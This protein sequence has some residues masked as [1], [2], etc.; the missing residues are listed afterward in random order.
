MEGRDERYQFTW[1]DKKKS[2]LL[3]NSPINATLRPCREESVDFDNTQNLYIEGDNLD[4]LKC[5]KETYLGKVK[6]IYI[7]PPYNT[8]NDFV[9]EDDFAE[10]SA[11]YLGNSG[12]F[13]EQ[14][15]KLVTNTESN[16]RFHTD[17]LNMIY[18]RL[19]V[20]RDLLTNDGV[21]FISIDDN[22]QSNLKK[23]C[24]E[25]FGEENCMGTIVWSK[26]RKGSFLSK[27]IISLTEYAIVYAKNRVMVS[28][29]YGGE[30]D[31]SESQPII[32]RTNKSSI[33]HIPADLINTKLDSG[34]YNSG[35]YGDDVN[36]VEILN[37]IIIEEGKI[38]ND[39]DIKAPFIWS[40]QFFN[41]QIKLGARFVINTLNF[42]IRVFK[43]QK[44][45][46]FKGFPSLVNGVE[47]GGTNEDAYEE[48]TN[49]FCI[50]NIFDY[51]KPTKYIKMLI[52]GICHFDKDS[53]ILDF[54]SGS[55][56][57]AHA[58]MQLNSEDKGNRKFI[59]VQLPEVTDEKSE[60]YKAGYK[61]I[62]EIGKE[63]IRRAGKKIEDELVAKQQKDG[64]FADDE[65]KYVLDKGFRV[66]KL[67]STNMEDI[68]YSPSEYDQQNL[69]A[70]TESVKADRTSEDLLFQVMLELGATLDSKI[71][72][73]VIGGKQI[74]NVADD[75]LVACFDAQIT[76][77]TVTAIAKMQPQYA[78]FRDSSMA[79]DATATNF[80]QIFKTYS[81][82]TK[83]KVL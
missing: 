9:Y 31:G 63:R 36:P 19:K 2:I 35:I 13:D 42:Q 1:P 80:E 5:L 69:F 8:G 17:W 23:I 3:A 58:V 41:E 18:P 12:Q 22:E 15:N 28:G 60:A 33:L 46:S 37:S 72:T 64:M 77:S 74:Y 39:F 62:C 79:D 76:D 70:K 78:V 50:K 45:G 49:F 24:D 68:Y 20:A 54:F 21:I 56:T 6:M 34:I 83:T 75:Y 25:I 48:L 38:I 53:I 73:K 30:A 51:S 61:N 32:K 43:I 40:Q 47:I 67:D 57:T 7:D 11:E 55:A 44:E 26:K 81:P 4:V 66:L 27:G 14:G 71:E 65:N 52:D 82:S 59:M 10:S 16:G 29:I